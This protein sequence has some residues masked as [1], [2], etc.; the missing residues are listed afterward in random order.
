M[1]RLTVPQFSAMKAAGRKVTMLT[2]YDYTM[3]R[4]VDQ[5][6]VDG[7]LVGDSMSMVVQGHEN[8][9]A[10]TLD[11]MIYHAEMVGRAVQ[12]ALV[13]VDMPFPTNLLGPYKAIENAGRI[14]KETGCEAVKLE[15][16]AEQAEIIAA[17]TSAGI[18]VMAHCGLCPQSVHQLGGYRVQRDAKQLMA[19]A[20]AAEKAGAFSVVLECIPAAVAQAV[21]DAIA[22]PTIGIGAGVGCD[23]QILVINDLL[24]ITPAPLPRHVK[25]YADLARQI[26]DAVRRYCED[27][28]SGAFPTEAQTFT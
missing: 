10:V 22:I 7:I 19:D 11:Q 14:L 13:V 8:T 6:G 2:A 15:G 17:L 9:L 23:G 25:T 21:T 27:V 1:A 26:D 20:C 16:G 12:R 24:G 28:R 18:P 3:A 5:A 4:L